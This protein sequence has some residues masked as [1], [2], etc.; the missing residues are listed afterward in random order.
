VIV[1]LAGAEPEKGSTIS[2]PPVELAAAVNSR[3]VPGTVVPKEIVCD[4]FGTPTVPDN[5]T[6]VVGVSISGVGT[7]PGEPGITTDT[8]I[9]R[10]TPL[11]CTVKVTVPEC[12]P[13]ANAEVFAVM[14]NTAAPPGVE[15]EAG[16]TLSQA[17]PSETA[18]V[19]AR[20]ASPVLATTTVPLKPKRVSNT[21]ELGYAFNAGVPVTASVTDKFCAATPG[22]ETL[23]VPT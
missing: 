7:E 5:S 10:V 11:G 4:G 8:G 17:A 12:L 22:A 15:P 6:D 21:T 9:I 3:V 18:V 2:Q 23:T 19:K 1:S 16:I 20:F 13:A 14:T